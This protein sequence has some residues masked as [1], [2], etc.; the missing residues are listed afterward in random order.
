MPPGGFRPIQ[1]TPARAGDD[2]PRP[3]VAGLGGEEPTKKAASA[4]ETALKQLL[5]RDAEFLRRENV[6]LG[7]VFPPPLSSDLT[8][9]PS[10]GHFLGQ[11]PALR[12]RRRVTSAAS[13]LLA[14]CLK[15]V[16]CLR[17]LR[18]ERSLPE[19]ERLGIVL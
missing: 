2:G 18:R 6:S 13:P 8:P 7:N 19:S 10:G 1:P 3:L 14:L 5:A 11:P 15:F 17:L 12:K 4:D 16:S 9:L